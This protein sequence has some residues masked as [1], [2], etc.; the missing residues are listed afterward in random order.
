MQAQHKIRYFLFVTEW[1][2]LAVPCISSQSAADHLR[3][4][5]MVVLLQPSMLGQL[6]HRYAPKSGILV[7]MGQLTRIEI[8]AIAL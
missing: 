5:L 3:Q 1:N 8:I 6:P 7:V 4:P 2:V